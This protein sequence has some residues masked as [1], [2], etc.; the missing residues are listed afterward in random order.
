MQKLTFKSVFNTIVLSFVF[1]VWIVFFGV[2]AYKVYAALSTVS[3]WTPLSADTWNNMISNF[4]WWSWSSGIYY[5]WWNNVW[6]WTTS[7]AGKFTIV[8]S[9]ADTNAAI[10]INNWSLSWYQYS[11]AAWRLRFQSSWWALFT[12]QDDWSV[13][14]W[15][16]N[17]VTTLHI[18]RTIV[19]NTSTNISNSHIYLRWNDNWYWFNM[20]IMNNAWYVQMKLNDSSSTLLPFL[21]NPD[22]WNVWIWTTNVNSKLTIW[23]SVNWTYEYTKIDTEWSGVKPP[24][25]DCDSNDE[26]WRMVFDYNSNCI[27]VCDYWYDWLCK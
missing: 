23:T 18:N 9:T 22:W 1:V 7:P 26:L 21:I 4:Y 20:W 8:Q 17:P 14:I 19:W 11:D 16:S 2:I 25:A 6:I 15:V 10:R 3:N 27:Y 24:A 13:W 12:I 5:N